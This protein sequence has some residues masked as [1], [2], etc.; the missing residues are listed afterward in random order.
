MKGHPVERF[1]YINCPDCP[2]VTVYSGFESHYATYHGGDRG[3]VDVREFRSRWISGE[4]VSQIHTCDEC[5]SMTDDL[6]AH[7]SESDCPLPEDGSSYTERGAYQ[8]YGQRH[9]SS[10]QEERVVALERDGYRCQMPECDVTD[11]EHRQ[12]DDLWPPQ[13]GLHVHHIH[14]TTTF[15]SPEEAD[16]ADNLISLCQKH[17]DMVQ[18]G[19][20][21][22][23]RPG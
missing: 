20:R 13:G 1:T 14:E 4:S 5:G 16:R 11:E 21:P 22:P 19:V 3:E 10:F 18:R 6:E 7:C 2:L 9:G 17:H 8:T 12:R 15:D 23:P